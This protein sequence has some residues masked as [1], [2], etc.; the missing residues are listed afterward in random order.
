MNAI[1]FK[2]TDTIGSILANFG[3]IKTNGTKAFTITITD[4]ESTLTSVK[5]SAIATKADK[6]SALATLTPSEQATLAKL[7]AK[8]D[9]LAKESAEKRVQGQTAE[10]WSTKGNISLG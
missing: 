9:K 10:R 8:V 5:V 6:E 2:G 7:Q 1:P 4:L 3:K